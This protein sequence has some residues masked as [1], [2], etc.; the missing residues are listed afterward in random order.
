MKTIFCRWFSVL[1]IGSL[2]GCARTSVAVDPAPLDRL[3]PGQVAQGDKPAPGDRF[4]FP[5]DKGGQ[6]LSELLRPPLKL[7]DDAQ[8]QPG[9]RPLVV[10][11]AVANPEPTLSNSPSGVPSAKLSPKAPPLRPRVLPEEAPLTAYRSDPPP[12]QRQEFTPGALVRVPSRDV[13]EP[14]PLPILA[15][16]GIDRAPLDDPTAEESLKVALAATMPVRSNPAPFVRLNLPDP[17]ENSHTVRLRS[18]PAEEQNPAS[19]PLRPPKP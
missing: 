19:G 2:A 15:N 17:F 6:A 1:L 5:A 7:S 18:L 10:P 14:I 16:P 8:A 9:P 11:P 12:V 3:N 4:T 13:N